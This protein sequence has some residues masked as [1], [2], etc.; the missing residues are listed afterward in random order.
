MNEEKNRERWRFVAIITFLLTWA[1]F[2]GGVVALPRQACAQAAPYDIVYVRWPRRGDDTIVR[3]PQAE[4]PYTVAPGADLVLLRSSGMQEV[5]VNCEECTVQDPMISFDG[6]WVYYTKML[7]AGD[8]R[9][10]SLLFKMRIAGD[11]AAYREIQLTFNDGFMG[12][13]HQ[14]NDEPEDD[15]GRYYSIR[16]MG[17]TPLPGGKIAFTSN[18]QATIP[19]RQ[20]STFSV[21]N[22]WV[23]TVSQ[24]FVMDD[25][26]GRLDTAD[27]SNLRQVGHGNL[28][29]TQHPFMLQDGRL[30][31]TNWDDAGGKFL[32]GM[33]TLY[34]MNPDGSHLQALTEPHNH[35][36]AADHFATQLGDGAIVTAQYYPSYNFGYGHLIRFPLDVEGPAYTARASTARNTHNKFPISFRNFDRKGLE[37]LTPHTAAEDCIAPDR[38]GKYCMPAAAPE[39]A[40]LVAY[41]PGGVNH[42][43]RCTK[44]DHD[45][46]DSG[47]YLIPD[48]VLGLVTDP[49]DARQL[50]E[51]LNSPDHNEIWPRPIVSY[52]EIHGILEPTALPWTGTREPLDDRLEPAEASAIVGTSSLYN[53]ESAP[54]R[55]DRFRP[56]PGREQHTGSWT[57]QGTDTGIVENSEIHAVRIIG[58][59]PKP[60]RKPIDKFA[61]ETAEEHRAVLHLIPD[62]RADSFVEGYGSVH[63]ERWKILGEFPVRKLDDKGN[64][65]LDPRGDPDTSFAAKI[66]ADTP[67]FFQGIDQNGMTLFSEL[68]WR[69]AV[70]GEVRTDCGGCHAHSIEPVDFAGTAAGNRL[71]IRVAGLN[72]GDPEISEGL[73]DLT[74]GRVPLVTRG[75][76]GIPLTRLVEGGMVD[77]EFHR[78][79]VPILENRCVSCHSTAA[80]RSGTDLA[81]DGATPEDDAY[82]RLVK[83]K[84]GAFGGEPPGGSYTY[85]QLSKYVRSNQ[86]R[87]SLLVWKLFGDRLDGRRNHDLAD[88]LDFKPHSKPHGA[89]SQECRT[90]A[91]WIDLG[92]PIDFESEIHAGYRY[93]DDCG[94]PVV[95]VA[96]PARG[97]NAAF[98]GTLQVGLADAES[99]IDW[100]SLEVSFDSILSDGVDLVSYIGAVERSLDGRVARVS[101]GDLF[102]KDR[103]HIIAVSVK[104]RAGNRNREAIRFWVSDDQDRPPDGSPPPPLTTRKFI[105]GDADRNGKRDIADPSAILAT[106]FGGRGTLRCDDAAD[107]N[108]DGQVNIADVIRLLYFLYIDGSTGLPEPS[109]EAGEDPTLDGMTCRF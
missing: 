97:W 100:D 48:A 81:F 80:N 107:A 26:D 102:E 49:G 60:F 16:D 59:V 52:E 99:G 14:G 33:T 10:P 41:S 23:M 62:A 12:G 89:T 78:D 63:G 17:P 6:E 58:V 57:I 70:A 108:D 76:G 85:P 98:D 109:L 43:V 91:R 53:R 94:L 54:L 20:G 92:C 7:D 95:R 18:R 31:F 46:L 21:T 36:K 19:F 27:L 3:L 39:G 32:Y 29:L 37:S 72:P 87:Q 47:I 45:V 11:G 2:L 79:I 96:S 77:L 15:L 69:A 34:T 101:F 30:L 56:L 40:L 22:A 5:L 64:A 93:S 106:L 25:H 82:F 9:S 42:N 44:G 1:G 4:D 50:V 61:V 38:S 88:D 65:I 13:R 68:T 105:R 104:D 84:S 67:F 24:I 8:E 28:H 71:P 35:H 75:A 66:P 51:I 103:E 83:D 73:W 86:A 90:I 74:T 55:T